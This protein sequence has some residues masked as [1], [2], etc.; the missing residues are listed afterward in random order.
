MP[1]SGLQETAWR[2]RRDLVSWVLLIATPCSKCID[3]FQLYSSLCFWI[4]TH[5]RNLLASPPRCLKFAPWMER[6]RSPLVWMERKILPAYN[7]HGSFMISTRLSGVHGTLEHEAVHGVCMCT[8]ASQLYSTTPDQ[9][10][11]LRRSLCA[12][13]RLAKLHTATG[14]GRKGVFS[15]IT[16]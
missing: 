6:K 14:G 9:R 10:H 15:T 4:Q 5:K 13:I 12:D 11:L 3:T 7:C 16:P 1:L 2:A 8:A